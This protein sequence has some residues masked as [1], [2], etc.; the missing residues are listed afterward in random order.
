M[1]PPHKATLT[2]E[3]DKNF[4]HRA[5]RCCAGPCGSG[6]WPS[7]LHWP[8]PPPSPRTNSTT[9]TRA[10]E[11]LRQ[12]KLVPR[13]FD[14]LENDITAYQLLYR[15]SANT[16]TEPSYTG[17]TVLVPSNAARDRLILQPAHQNS[18]SAACAASHRIVQSLKLE[19]MFAAYTWKQ[20]LN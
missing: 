6:R 17:T 3:R 1:D 15:T 7:L 8:V 12:R 2:D 11:V 16:P 5:P 9:R 18:A 10:G 14:W 4:H 19:S 20:F 13:L